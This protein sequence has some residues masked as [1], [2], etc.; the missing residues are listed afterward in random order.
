MGVRSTIA[1]WFSSKKEVAEPQSMVYQ[2]PEVAYGHKYQVYDTT[3]DGEKTLGE[4]GAI[5]RTVPNYQH[6]RLRMYHA[7]A[8]IDTIKIIASKFF[9]WT[10]GSGLKLQVEP[11]RTVLESEGIVNSPEFWAKFQ[12][13]TEARFMIYANSKNSDYAKE[14]NLHTLALNTY[15]GEFLGGDML[16]VIR[17]EDYG[18]TMQVISGEHVCNPP[19]DTSK[20]WFEDAKS[21]GNKIKHGIELDKKNSHVAYYVRKDSK[22]ITDDYERIPAYGKKSGE[23]LAWMVSGQKISLDHVRSVP[24][25][26]QSLEKINKLDR[27]TE[28]AVTK[29]EQ[30]AKVVYSIEHQEYSTGEN[31]LNQVVAN[32][33]GSAVMSIDYDKERA[34]ADG[35]ANRITETTS[36]QA[37]NMPNGAQMKSFESSIESKFSEFKTNL[38]DEISAGSDVPPE[39]SM[40][41]YSSN[42]SASR[43]AIN[44]FGYIIIINRVKFANDFYLPFYKLW[45]KHQILTNKISAPGYIE[46]QDNFMVTESYSQ[47]RFTGKNMPH[48]D[49]LKEIKAVREMLG[50]SDTTPLISREQ[51]VEMLNAGQWD[52][53]FLK[54]LEEEN[55]I[56]AEIKE[57][58]KEEK[59]EKPKTEPDAN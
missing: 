58:G 32:K 23:R 48:I 46:N 1:G 27:Y 18:P 53:N 8:T 35:L 26:S 54:Y 16:C 4:L 34:L 45:L 19:L 50:L 41:K 13:L 29:A 2:G 42:Y 24:Q 57:K 7:F 9:Y 6:L 47:C 15:Q 51:A 43:A 33:R 12:K 39:V 55:I 30:G 21:N 3:W 5:K 37:F 59:V 40:Q 17:F 52:E 28:A 56:P 14:N 11:N 44:S 20:T 22:D 49:P 10:I 31:P 36:G 38:F 25:M